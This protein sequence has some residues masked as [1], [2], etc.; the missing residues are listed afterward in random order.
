MTTLIF[1]GILQW[2]APSAG[3]D[4][5]SGSA[6]GMSEIWSGA[7]DDATGTTLSVSI[8]TATLPDDDPND[9]S[10]TVDACA[11]YNATAWAAHSNAR[12]RARLPGGA[13]AGFGPMEPAPRLLAGSGDIDTGTDT[14]AGRAEAAAHCVLACR[15]TQGLSTTG[16]ILQ[17]VAI[18][19]LIGASAAADGRPSCCGSSATSG[20]IAATS[21]FLAC[22]A[23]TALWGLVLYLYTSDTCGQTKGLS[24]PL[25]TPL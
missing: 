25:P 2:G 15:A 23:Y 3:E 7:T 12:A 5:D 17:F 18:F 6:L 10:V 4:S 20:G 1:T 24:A 13:A 21:L 16:V 14:S 9:S 22:M 19:F 8:W 11:F